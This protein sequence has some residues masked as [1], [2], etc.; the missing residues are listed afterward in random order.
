MALS[1]KRFF[2]LSQNVELYAGGRF[3]REWPS[4]LSQARL[5][6]VEV[7]YP[8][9]LLIIGGWEQW[10]EPGLRQASSTIDKIVFNGD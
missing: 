9:G 7:A 5:G 8:G 4:L 3:E 10:G 2:D 1:I 6:S